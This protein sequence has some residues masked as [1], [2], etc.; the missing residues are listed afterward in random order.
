M[1]K[2]FLRIIAETYLEKEGDNIQDYCFVFPNRRSSLFFRKY[3]GLSSSK[4][5]FVPSLVTINDLFATLSGLVQ[6]D[7]IELLYILYQC[8]C[9]HIH[10]YKETF[11]DFLKWGDTILS[12]F[13]DIDKYLA[14]AQKLF[15]N[16]R[17]LKE[18]D[19]LY[20]YLSQSQIEAIKEFWNHFLPFAKGSKEKVFMDVWSHLYD[21][22]EEFNKTLLAAGKGYEGMIYRRVSD[23]LSAQE[24]IPSQL[25]GYK[26]I[27]F[28]G[29]NALNECEKS[30]MDFLL[31]HGVADFYW[32]YY[33]SIITDKENKSSLFMEENVRKY[34]SL[35]P[36]SDDGEGAEEK[37]NIEVIGIPSMVGQTKYL[38]KLLKEIANR[39][40]DDEL[41]STAIVLPDEKL[42]NPVLNSIPTEVEKV[43]VTMGYTLS[44]S[45]LA[46]FMSLV[47]ALQMKCKIQGGKSY[48]YY[49]TVVDILSHPF[50]RA[51][52]QEDS[53]SITREIID[54]NMIMVPSDV[55]KG[56]S[57]ISFIFKPL[58]LPPNDKKEKILIIAHYQ[59]KIL[60]EL[61]SRISAV[62]KEYVYQY[63][64]C[65][66]RLMNLD[67]EMEVETYFSLLAQIVFSISIPFRGEPL[68]GL[69][70][71]GPLETRA[72]DFENVI[73]LSMNEGVFPSRNVSPS[74]I[75]YNLRKGFGLP[76]Y[77]YQDSIWAYYFYRSI[78]R[79]SNVYL[80]YD[81]RTEGIKTGEVSR[82]VKQL[83]YHHNVP[84]TERI[85]TYKITSSPSQPIEVAKTPEI[86]D[87]LSHLNYSYSSVNT[88]MGCPLKFYFQYVEGMKETDEV[89]ENVRY[90][91]FGS[92]F[93]KVVE[94]IYA[95]FEGHE[96]SPQ[97][98][99]TLA[100]DVDS[101]SLHIRNAFKEILN[102][103]EIKGKNKVIEALLIRYVKMTLEYDATL[104]TLRY[105]SGEKPIG[106]TLLLPRSESTVR[107]FGYIDRIDTIKGLTRIID[108]KTGKVNMPFKQLD[109]LFD[110]TNPNR[111]YTAF[112]LL[113]YLLL[114][115]KSGLVSDPSSAQMMVY[116]LKEIYKHEL[117]SLQVDKDLLNEFEVLLVNTLEGIFDINVPFTACVDD[118]ICKKC[119][120]II[121]CNR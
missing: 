25:A 88:Y 76:T 119:P 24:V 14:D 85:M 13:D 6:A 3:L 120:F 64:T 105:I 45:Y 117:P 54:K 108:Y 113:F 33:G 8:Y 63:Y 118:D 7:N 31:G 30:L 82:Y 20:S 50:I 41:F 98:F 34:Q 48:Y 12:D 66:Q 67:I 36:I 89:S 104:P 100:K 97:K 78:Y 86:L 114:V 80:I 39:S 103:D 16:V 110:M 56:D 99:H 71:M 28:I 68:S 91:T 81:T 70:I 90:D 5:L 95:P 102:V 75:P 53:L 59:L 101:I 11:D 49:S 1:R 116:T 58:N 27:I 46:S 83:K 4:P 69:Q 52:A 74:F 26:R 37:K 19:A 62:E 77:E 94:K 73:F 109:E 51:I 42:L 106:A 18:I 10:S 107:L 35:F 92:I 61:Q 79:A 23:E 47:S 96:I 15:I 21:I 43:N 32:D 65:I 112:Q 121:I 111:A 87:K 9:H 40:G 38:T 60:E 22:Y 44:N 29:L 55:I 17:E 115:T 57:I 2:E 72:L 93:H 84:L